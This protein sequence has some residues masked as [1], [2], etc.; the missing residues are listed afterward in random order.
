M[1]GCTDVFYTDDSKA[2]QGSGAGVQ[3]CGFKM[4][5]GF[6]LNG[7]ILNGPSEIQPGATLT[8]SKSIR[9]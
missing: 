4:E 5:T 9:A 2:E 3:P 6:L 7:D 8:S 1:A